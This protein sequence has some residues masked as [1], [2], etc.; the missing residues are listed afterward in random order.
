MPDDI[1]PIPPPL[2][3]ERHTDLYSERPAGASISMLVIHAISEFVYWPEEKSGEPT[4][5]VPALE[6]LSRAIPGRKPCSAHAAIDPGGV[7]YRVCNDGRMAWHAGESAFEGETNLNRVSLGVELMVE[8]EH[9]YGTFLSR[10][11]SP[12][13]FTRLQYRALGWLAYDWSRSYAIPPQRIVGH[14]RIAGDDVRGAG[15][16]KRDPGAGFSFPRL[17]SEMIAWQER[18]NQLGRPI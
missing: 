16:G 5:F 1:P 17:R 8:G 11:R 2:V 15:K 18:D 14:N 10:I 6:W 3:I 7:I 13:C 4:R 9:T 12:E